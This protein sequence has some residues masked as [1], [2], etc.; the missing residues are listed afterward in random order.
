MG[1]NS[2]GK[3]NYVTR[4]TRHVWNGRLV[5]VSFSFCFFFRKTSECCCGLPASV[6]A[7]GGRV[8]LAPYR[9]STCHVDRPPYRR[10]IDRL[11][12]DRAAGR[13]VSRAVS[14]RRRSTFK[15]RS[16]LC[17]ERTGTGNAIAYLLY[18]GIV[19]GRSKSR[20]RINRVALCIDPLPL[21]NC[22]FCLVCRHSPANGQD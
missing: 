4:R 15:S 20:D 12:G 2:N 8:D 14:S 6:V 18:H 7:V 1:V 3:E 9:A 11:H 22:G 17:N 19:C 5:I 13:P 21:Y 10:P 16:R